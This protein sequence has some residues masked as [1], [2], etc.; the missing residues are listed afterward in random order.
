MKEDLA[1][2][3]AWFPRVWRDGPGWLVFLLVTSPIVAFLQAGF[4][5]LWQYAVDALGADGRSLPQVA[6]WTAGVGVAHAALYVALQ[7]ARSVRNGV[8]SATLRGDLVQAVVLAE[9]AAR[10]GWRTGD[11]VARIHDDAGEK[12]SWFL[13]SGIFRA[14]EAAWIAVACLLAM[15]WTEPSLMIWV[16][17]PLPVVAWMQVATQETLS[18]RQ[19]EVQRAIS[20]TAE[21]V[22]STFTT[23]RVVQA[24]G[25]VPFVHRRFLAHGEAQRDAEI[26]ASVVS[27]GMALVFQY[28]WQF[29][30][31]ALLWFGGR[32]VIDGELTLGGYVTFEGLLSTLVWPMF[33]LGNLLSRAAPTAVSLRR[34]DDVLALPAA[35]E[36]TAREGGGVLE[37]DGLAVAAPDGRPLVSGISL[38][39][40]PG[41]R[42]ALAGELGAGKTVVLEA[43]A[44]SRPSTGRV[45][46]G[47]VSARALAGGR[48][49]LVPQDPVALRGTLRENVLLGRSVAEGALEAAVATSQLAR[50]L[51]QLPRG[52]DTEVG[53]RG[54]TLSGGQRQ[55]L[56]IAR[57]LVGEPA[58]LLL[59][60]ATSALDATV[61]AALWDALEARD[62]VAVVLVTHRVRALAAAR[63]VLFLA[64]GRVAD[65]GTHAELLERCPAYRRS[66]G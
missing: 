52:L 18:R 38:R 63:E 17:A 46:V 37:V 49:V 1:V 36:G 6:G 20:E 34:L 42:V 39:V 15:A 11:L 50:D 26:R 61:E 3:R 9:P 60:D 8:I 22:E 41:E 56:A 54:V 14:Y 30:L 12:L 62:A 19:K 58:V 16:V 31:V 10:A 28:G 35:T 66:Y 55:R 5:W 23:L 21:V 4:P 43:L 40:G 25:L 7:W 51:G 24:A 13:C 45:S 33:D 47:G 32:R 64:E 53:E 44:G 65:R 27:G 29:A 57:A 2:I 59:D 48:V